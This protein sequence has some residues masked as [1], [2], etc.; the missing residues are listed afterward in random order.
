MNNPEYFFQFN[1]KCNNRK[2]STLGNSSSKESLF[3]ATTTVTTEDKS[4]IAL[5]QQEEEQYNIK[6]HRGRL[7][8]G[9]S[10]KSSR[11][12]NHS[13]TRRLCSTIAS[14]CAVIYP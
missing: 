3:A 9:T 12:T 7:L 2:N 13:N 8:Q 14:Y 4:Q 6:P 11:I 10:F 5:Q 1:S